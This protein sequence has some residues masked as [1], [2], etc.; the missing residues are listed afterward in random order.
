MKVSLFNLL[1]ICRLP[2]AFRKFKKGGNPVGHCVGS[3]T[4]FLVVELRKLI[5][6]CTLFRLLSLT[7]LPDLFARDAKR[8][9]LVNVTGKAYRRLALNE[10]PCPIMRLAGLLKLIHLIVWNVHGNADIQ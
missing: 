3:L 10:V 7:W 2:V 4:V 9:S 5:E 6:S 8:P 1:T